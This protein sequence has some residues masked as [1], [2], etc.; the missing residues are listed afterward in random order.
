MNFNETK[1]RPE[2]L[3]ALEKMNFSAMTE[4]Q[5]RAV[6]SGIEGKD[7]LAQ[8]Q[9]GTGKTAAFCLP[10]INQI[11]NNDSLQAI[12]L[13]PTRELA[14]QITTEFKKM[15]ANLPYIKSMSVYGGDPIDKQMKLLRDRPQVVI[16]T[17][18]RVQDLIN[19]KKLK[20]HEIRFFVLDEVD[21][22][23][24]MGFIDD[25]IEIEKKM[26]R[27]KQTLFFSATMPNQIKKVSSKFLKD[28]YDNIKVDAKSLTVDKVEQFYI[29][30]KDSRKYEAL[31]NVLDAKQSKKT[32][33]FTQTK[34]KAD[35]TFDFLISQDFKIE[36]IHGDLSQQ[37]RLQTINRLRNGQVDIIVAT[38]VVARGIDIDGIELVINLQLPQDIEYYIHRIGRTGRAGKK[39]EAITIVSHNEYK[40]QFQNYPRQLK[41]TITEMEIPK[42]DEIINTQMQREYSKVA[43]VL[44]DGEVE[45]V[46]REMANMFDEDDLREVLA[47]V[48]Q[49][50]YPQLSKTKRKKV[51]K[52]QFDK[53]H[54]HRGEGSG[55][56][57]GGRRGGNG[58]G[59]RRGGRDGGRRDGGRSDRKRDGSRRNRKSNA[60]TST[61]TDRSRKFAAGKRKQDPSRRKTVPQD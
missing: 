41:C 33:I 52:E 31:K 59:G 51:I 20:L 14:V 12:M 34:R 32:I 56:G 58:G 6:V 29:T 27:E 30:C 47:I 35:E 36:K 39:G 46:F 42:D 11:E 38:D 2:I 23:L 45:S 44:V 40:R 26:P 61:Q 19:R 55:N 53:I 18:G 1:L 9:T 15:S 60:S 48:F 3:S 7:I 10:I 37:Q 21:E 4:I 13:A 49:E 25:V 24:N 17:P 5:E 22:M 43:K 16:G 54:G 8:A 57:G 50:N 28:G